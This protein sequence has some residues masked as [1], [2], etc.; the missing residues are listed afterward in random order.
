MYKLDLEQ[1]GLSA[2]SLEHREQGHSEFEAGRAIAVAVVVHVPAAAAPAAGIF[3]YEKKKRLGI[4]RVPVRNLTIHRC[5]RVP[6]HVPRNWIPN[7][8]DFDSDCSDSES[9]CDEHSISHLHLE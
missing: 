8:L 9:G 2:G 1:F 6:A 5:S 7:S 4:V 3:E